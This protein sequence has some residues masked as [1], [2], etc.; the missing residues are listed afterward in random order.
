[1]PLVLAQLENEWFLAAFAPHLR[2]CNLSAPR[3]PR[4]NGERFQLTA[5][6]NYLWSEAPLDA[7]TFYPQLRYKGCGAAP[8]MWR[9]DSAEPVLYCEI[10]TPPAWP[11]Q[12][13]DAK[14]AEL[15]GEGWK[16][17]RR[18][19]IGRGYVHVDDLEKTEGPPP[20]GAC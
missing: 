8:V 20:A 14:I 16:W 17:D 11:P 6:G 1:M 5:R 4:H 13:R 19:M 7:V 15:E 10:G 9:Q 2:G 3:Q 18:D 12:E